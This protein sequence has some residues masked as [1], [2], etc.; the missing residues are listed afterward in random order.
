MKN[1]L[2]LALVALLTVACNRNAIDAVNLSNEGDKMKETSP[3]EAISKY[4]QASQLDPENTRIAWRLV[5]MYKRKEAWDK[6]ASTAAKASKKA[7]TF[8][9]FPY[10]HGVAL[11][12]Q[13]LKTG[14]GWADAKGPLEEAIKID[15][16][17]ADAHFELAEVMLHLDDENAALKSYTKAI[18][19]KPDEA[20]FYGP[21]AEL[22][23][24]L[25]LL[26][27]AE[28][29][30]KEGKKFVKE[31]DKHA[32]ILH[33]I[34]GDVLEKKGDASGAIAS[35]EAAL[36][37]C[38]QCTQPGEPITYFNL[39][40]AYAQQK[41]KSEAVSKLTSFNKVVCKGAAA[42]RYA[43]QCSTA[44]QVATQLGATLQ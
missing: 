3:D 39:G 16:N 44:Q 35:Y 18:E 26:D 20:S 43:D 42:A 1:A 12:R 23:T 4:E 17:L 37:A 10:M 6:V 14:N 8:A 19:M 29:V 25:N 5:Q 27:Q 40:V 38:G 22:Y 11:A 15:P 13:A 2:R 34:H 30:V 41:R 28:G 33:S 31:G 21:L 24:R 9:T 36:K 7:P 32:Y